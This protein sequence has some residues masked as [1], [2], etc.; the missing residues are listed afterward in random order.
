MQIY[1]WALHSVPLFYVICLGFISQIYT[2]I[3]QLNRKKTNNP[4]LKIGKG[5]EKYLF[6]DDKQMA[7]RYMKIWST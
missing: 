5:P 2:E 3:K 6:K 4:I 1:C 7:N